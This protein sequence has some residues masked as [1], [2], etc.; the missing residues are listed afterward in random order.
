MLGF[1]RQKEFNLFFNHTFHKTQHYNKMKQ[2]IEE[3]VLCIHITECLSRGSCDG[4]GTIFKFGEPY[5][6]CKDYIGMK[7]AER[8]ADRKRYL[9][10]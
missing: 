5:A 9:T 8:L 2:K 7:D 6:K 1:K 3:K 4:K 10:R